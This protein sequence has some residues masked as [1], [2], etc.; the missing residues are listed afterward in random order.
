MN[1]FLSFFNSSLPFE[2][3]EITKEKIIAGVVLIFI[4]FTPSIIA[5]DKI[6]FK[7]IFLLN[8]LAG[9]TGLGWLIALV[10][11]IVAKSKTIDLIG[12]EQDLED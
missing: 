6:Q 2:N 3:N 12:E 10:L 9:W 7:L 4:Y 8:L 1:H 11:A 5:R